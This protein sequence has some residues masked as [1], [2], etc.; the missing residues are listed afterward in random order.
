MT[1]RIPGCAHLRKREPCSADPARGPKQQAL[2]GR[3]SGDADPLSKR[4][5]CDCVYVHANIGRVNREAFIIASAVLL[6]FGNIVLSFSK[7]YTKYVFYFL[8]LFSNGINFFDNLQVVINPWNPP[9][10]L[11]AVVGEGLQPFIF[12]QF[13]IV[14]INRTPS[15]PVNFAYRGSASSLIISSSATFLRPSTFNLGMALA[16]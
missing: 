5:L 4:L 6:A 11:A 15:D 3:G 13:V 2:A 7:T 16:R 1:N 14:V 9:V 10:F 8:K 12:A